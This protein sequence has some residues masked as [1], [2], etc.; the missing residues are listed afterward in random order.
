MPMG[1]IVILKSGSVSAAPMYTNKIEI[2]GLGIYATGGIPFKAAVEAAIDRSINI[3]DILGGRSF[4]GPLRTLTYDE[5]DDH[6]QV[7]D[8]AGA[9]VANGTDLVGLYRMTVIGK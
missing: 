6:L 8:A 4:A 3:I 2:D 9:E 1:P 7:W 5:T